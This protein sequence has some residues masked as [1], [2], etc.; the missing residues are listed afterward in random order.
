MVAVSPSESH[1]LAVGQLQH[2]W[3]RNVAFQE[4]ARF[5]FQTARLTYH[6]ELADLQI[7]FRA[8]DDAADRGSDWAVLHVP[9]TVEWQI[10]EGEI[11]APEIEAPFELSLTVAG[12]FTWE[13]APPKR[14]SQQRWLDY[15]GVYLLW[16]YLRSY[17]AMITGASSL[18]PL[19]IYT[20]RVPELPS[21]VATENELDQ[22]DSGS[23]SP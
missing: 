9:A 2:A 14:E 7:D 21:A 11:E 23:H 12:L 18:P 6:V 10:A 15:N 1:P 16:P 3:L 20:R 4:N 5:D 8:D 22:V 17:V 19:T 13:P